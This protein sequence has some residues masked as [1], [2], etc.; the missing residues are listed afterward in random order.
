M[1]AVRAS[2]AAAVLLC[3]AWPALAAPGLSEDCLEDAREGIARGVRYLVGGQKEDGSWVQEPA[4]TALVCLALA[5][6][7]EP[8]EPQTHTATQKAADFVRGLAKYI[9]S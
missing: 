6:S 2:V 7:T 5:N 9:C 8:G 1:R 4:T 3:A